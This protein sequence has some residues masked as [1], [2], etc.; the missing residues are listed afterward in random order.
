V[1]ITNWLHQ[2][3]AKLTL[4]FVLIAPLK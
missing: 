1:Y 2:K 4:G 3:I